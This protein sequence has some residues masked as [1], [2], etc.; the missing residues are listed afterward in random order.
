MHRAGFVH[1][2]ITLNNIIVED[3]RTAHL[4]DFES[5]LP[6]HLDLSQRRFIRL[7]PATA[8]PAFFVREARVT[9]SDDFI[10]LRRVVLAAIS[11]KQSDLL[12]SILVRARDANYLLLDLKQ[13]ARSGLC[14]STTPTCDLWRGFPTPT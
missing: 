8:S 13:A 4:I 9:Y 12:S 14:W 3:D 10:S 6:L 2:D 11:G 5:S 7:T 1:G